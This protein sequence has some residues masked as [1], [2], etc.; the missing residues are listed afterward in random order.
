MLTLN[1][2]ETILKGPSLVSTKIYD[3]FSYYNHLNSV[4]KKETPDRG[5]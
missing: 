5:L 4:I 2:L 1:S 3:D